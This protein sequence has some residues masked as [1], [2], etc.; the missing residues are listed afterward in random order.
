[1]AEGKVTYPIVVALQHPIEIGSE[2]IYELKIQRPKAK[3]FERFNMGD[4][5]FTDMLEL[6]SQLSAPPEKLLKI[7]RAVDLE[8]RLHRSAYAHTLP[9]MHYEEATV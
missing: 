6:L 2:T 7:T 5:Q 1:M 4:P 3:H 8:C 9:V